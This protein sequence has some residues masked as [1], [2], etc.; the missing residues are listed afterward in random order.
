MITGRN[1]RDQRENI[2]KDVKKEEVESTSE[3]TYPGL[4]AAESR[5]GRLKQSQKLNLRKKEAEQSK[6][7]KKRKVNTVVNGSEPGSSS[8][9]PE[10]NLTIKKSHLLFLVR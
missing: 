7:S 10:F 4:K 6:K 3:S 1:K 8:P 5:V 9:C 2:Y